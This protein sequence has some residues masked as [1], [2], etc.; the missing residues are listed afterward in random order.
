MREEERP[1][2]RDDSAI[3]AGRITTRDGIRV[4]FQFQQSKSDSVERDENKKRKKNLVRR[5]DE[6]LEWAQSSTRFVSW[7]WAEYYEWVAACTVKWKWDER[8]GVR[9]FPKY[10]ELSSIATTMTKWPYIYGR[11]SCTSEVQ[12]QLNKYPRENI[13]IKVESVFFSFAP[14]QQQ[15][16]QLAMMTTTQ[17]TTMS[18]ETTYQAAASRTRRSG[19]INERMSGM[20]NKKLILFGYFMLGVFFCSLHWTKPEW[21]DGN[22]IFERNLVNSNWQNKEKH[23]Q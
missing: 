22:E 20:R 21:T 4:V 1:R 18:V 12:L 23:E 3:A 6:R 8:N 9:S 13:Q 19:E 17:P 5:D 14:K 16:L 10:S 15:R 7:A 2:K 11:V